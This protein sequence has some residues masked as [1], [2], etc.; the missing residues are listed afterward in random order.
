MRVHNLAQ[1]IIN[2][3][4]FIDSCFRWVDPVRSMIAFIVSLMAIHSFF[5]FEA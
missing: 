5:R 1:S 2:A 4:N 3:G